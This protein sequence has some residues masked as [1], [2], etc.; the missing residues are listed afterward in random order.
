MRFS[1]YAMEDYGLQHGG[2]VVSP[3][4]KAPGSEPEWNLYWASIPELDKYLEIGYEDFDSFKLLGETF[5]HLRRVKLQEL[6]KA[7]QGLAKHLELGTPAQVGKYLQANE[8]LHQMYLGD[9][10]ATWKETVESR[11]VMAQ[12]LIDVKDASALCQ[13]VIVVDFKTRRRL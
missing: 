3:F 11:L 13:S 4:G 8:R 7:D 12:V 1:P 5:P 9:G 2:G 6:F 10:Y